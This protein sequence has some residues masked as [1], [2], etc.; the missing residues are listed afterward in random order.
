VL[1]TNKLTSVARFLLTTD[2]LSIVVLYDF[3]T[4]VCFLIKWQGLFSLI[5][6]L[7]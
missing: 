2:A 6:S 5:L 7:R 1:L 4:R 3:N